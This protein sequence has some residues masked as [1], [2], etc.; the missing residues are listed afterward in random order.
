MVLLGVNGYG[1][2]GEGFGGSDDAEGDLAAVS[3]EELG[4]FIGG[5]A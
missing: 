1:R 3:D 5:H 4:R 2:D